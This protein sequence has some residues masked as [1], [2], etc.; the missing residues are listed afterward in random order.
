M[1]GHMAALHGA[2]REAAIRGVQ[3]AAA[4]CIQVIVTKIVPSRSPQPVDRGVFRAGWKW[5]PISMGAEIFNTEPHA[6]FIEHGVRASSVKPG[7]AMI[8]ALAE[9][10]VRKRLAT[11]AEA[12]SV[13]WRIAKTMRKR[14]IFN[15]GQGFKILD[16][17]KREH[18]RPL[19]R[20]EVAREIARVQV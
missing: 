8:R 2:L 6:A 1:P 7:G 16:E 10:V 9:W 12:I 4:R 5:L 18:A 13:A 14:G 20:E 11:G 17:L 15:G 19:I 3:A